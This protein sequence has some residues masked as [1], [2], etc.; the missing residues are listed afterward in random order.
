M[1]IKYYCT[2]A[3]DDLQENEQVFIEYDLMVSAP[4]LQDKQFH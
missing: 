1:K 4:N 2:F 3:Q